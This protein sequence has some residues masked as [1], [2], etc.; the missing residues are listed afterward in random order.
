MLVHIEKDM[1]Y[2]QHIF[3]FIPYRKTKTIFIASGELKKKNSVRCFN[4]FKK[5]HGK[6]GNNKCSNEI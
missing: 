4:T 3:N 6:C 2:P 5:I 1:I